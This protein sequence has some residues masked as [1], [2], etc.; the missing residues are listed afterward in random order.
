MA[1]RVESS[2]DGKYVGLTMAIAPR[3]PPDQVVTAD[4]AVFDPTEWTEIEPGIWRI[5][6]PHY[7]V[8]AR[9]VD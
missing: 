2:T 1:L 8:I 6:N 7:C 9:E 5:R 4:G 3:A